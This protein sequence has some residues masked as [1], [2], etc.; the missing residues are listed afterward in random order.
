MEALTTMTRRVVVTGM[1]TVNPL[2]LDVEETWR[3]IIHGSSG[4]GPIS[5]FDH[6]ELEVHIAAEVK[7]FEP[8]DYMDPKDARR[9]DRF[10]QLAFA[11]VR[12]AVGQSGMKITAANTDRVAIIVSSAVGGL[13]TIVEAV[14]TLRGQGPRR[15]SP[16]SIPMYMPNGASGR[17]GI[18]LGIKGPSFSIASAC[19]SGGDSIGQAAMLIQTGVVDAA[20]AGASEAT[21]TELGVA[22]F[23]RMGA[24]SRR[25]GVE[26]PTPA[27]F[28]RDR[29]GL[30]MGEGAAVLA[31]EAL[32]V[33][34]E[35]DAEIL[36][37]LIGY[38]S[39]ADAYHI[40]APAKD[41]EGGAAAIRRALADGGLT[42]E[43]VDYIN[44]HGTGT[45]LNDLAET[46][47]I[48][49]VFGETA[50]RVPVSSTKSMTGHLMG[51]TGA[52]EAIFCV[53]AIRENLI[54]PTINLH[55]PD[56]ECD[57]DYVPNR[58]RQTSVEVAI[59]NAFGFGGHNAVLALAAYSR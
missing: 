47:A 59:S 7:G 32:E 14:D 16:F 34:Q 50:Y 13:G 35:R 56:P 22:V 25:D 58:P 28:D 15:V 27:P 9:T 18:E 46:A 57:L 6:S 8:T 20:L 38:G 11:A 45:V 37:E 52:L 5:L 30:V 2:G 19:A 17:I 51:A 43:D 3:N 49:A 21:V 33:A 36:A 10:Q 23:D 42:P 12:E 39:S 4:V 48:K 54:P 31:L 40:T 1:G 26:S 55:N 53:R 29:D 44:A 24:L 41:G